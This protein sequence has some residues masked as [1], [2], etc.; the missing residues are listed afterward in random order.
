MDPAPDG[1]HSGL[2]PAAFAPWLDRQLA[3]RG[4]SGPELARRLTRAG[5]PTSRQTVNHWAIGRQVPSPVRLAALA[6]VLGV[7]VEAVRAAPPVDDPPA[8]AYAA[9]LLDAL[10]DDLRAAAVAMLEALAEHARSRPP[11]GVEKAP[12]TADPGPR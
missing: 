7:P 2:D 8:A 9:R 6:A 11:G 1:R 12:T 10:P 4:W 3:R 5:A